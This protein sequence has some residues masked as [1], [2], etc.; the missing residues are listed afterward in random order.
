[1]ARSIGARLRA[2][3]E[4]AGLTIAAAAEKLHVDAK[5]IE[6][7][8]SKRFASSARRCYVRG[9]L[10]RY[11]DLIGERAPQL[12][13]ALHR[14]R[15]ASAAAGSHAGAAPGRRRIRAGSWRRWSGCLRA[16]VLALA[17]WWI[18]AGSKRGPDRPRA[19]GAGRRRRRRRPHRAVRWRPPIRP[20]PGRDAR[21]CSGRPCRHDHGR[22]HRSG[23]TGTQAKRPRRPAPTRLTLEF[24]ADSW[25]EVYDRAA[26]ACFTTSRPPAACRVSTGGRRC[27]SFSAMRRA[28][29]VEVDGQARERAGQRR[30]GRRRALH[31][32]SHRLAVAGR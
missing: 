31:R 23:R 18:L 6:A 29:R 26:S 9:H 10:R 20:A 17:I 14:A 2:G 4:R 16:A 8:E 21:G 15:G 7:L 24:T 3:R 12:V 5:V 32:Q 1:M 28:F 27:A 30:R 25:V 13:A 22:A 11:A 19:C